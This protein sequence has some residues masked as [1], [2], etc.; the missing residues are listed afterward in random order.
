VQNGGS[1]PLIADA[2]YVY[3]SRTLFND[4]SAVS[5]VTLAPFDAILLQRQIQTHPQAITF[6]A[7]SDQ[8][9]GNAPL[10]ISPTASSGLPVVVAS[11]TPATCSVAGN[12][13]TLIEPGTC[14]LIA[15]QSGGGA[16]L[17]APDVVQSFTILG[18]AEMLVS[19]FTVPAGVTLGTPLVFTEGLP[20]SALR[21][22]DFTLAST[23]CTGASAGTC[24]VNVNFTSQFAGLRRGAVKIVDTQNNL[25]A[26]AY[27]SG[28][29]AN[30]Q[31]AF[32]P[33]SLQKLVAPG[34][35]SGVT[36]DGAGNM[37]FVTDSG[38]I[39]NTKGGNF[40]L[41][42]LGTTL[43]SPFGLA[44][45]GA[46]NLY[47]A[48][49]GNNRVLELPYGSSTAVALTVTGLNYP[50]AV[51]VDGAGNILI[52]NTRG[53]AST[54]NGTVIELASGSHAQSTVIGAGLSF[55]VGV[56]FDSSGDLF[57]A[58]SG[59]NRVLEVSRSGESASI[60][61]GLA[62][63]SAVGVDAL[64]DVF[65]ADQ[66]NNRLVEVPGTLTGPGTGTQV[67][68][69]TGLPQPH[70]MALDGPGNIYVSNL[71]TTATSGNAVKVPKQ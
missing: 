44:L 16:Y 28:I 52:A 37:Y 13:V 61:T 27:I 41:I 17:P 29:G 59:A 47:I 71:G 19:T 11:S 54:G 55:P 35:V 62:T 65:I 5:Q 58:D 69:A 33:G 70:G 14:T 6:N 1:G 46:G 22:P 25:I 48:D 53:S 43:N 26:T 63:A 9:L 2:V 36:V 45:D 32:T 49:S 31:S 42:S 64:G 40:N 68:V 57:V 12:L 67:T 24:V 60:G 7:L 18:T 38:Q 23:T 56:T 21:S 8:P 15:S 3:S 39:F 4:G 50:Q 10:V 20:A 30:S 66:N 51:A 34:A